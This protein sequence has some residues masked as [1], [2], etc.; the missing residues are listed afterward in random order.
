M[1]KIL[2]ICMMLLCL[3]API[4][5]Q[6][7]LAIVIGN[8]AYQDVPLS[9]PAGN[10]ITVSHSLLGLGFDVIRLEDANAQA[11]QFDNSKADTVIIYFSGKV[12]MVDKKTVLWSV[13]QNQKDDPSGWHL[14]DL[15]SGFMDAGSKRVLVF[16]DICHNELQP[17]KLEALSALEIDNVFQAQ[18]IKPGTTCSTVKETSPDFTQ[19][20]I[21]TLLTPN[22]PLSKA[23]QDTDA[24]W[25]TSSLSHP[26][27]LRHADE[28]IKGLTSAD[29]EMLDRLSDKD[30]KKMLSLWRQAGIIQDNSAGL[31]TP[32]ST[33]VIPKIRKTTI[34]FTA[35]VQ[36]INIASPLKPVANIVLAK[37]EPHA[38]GGVRI[39][40]AVASSTNP[41]RQFQPTKAGLPK[42]SI[43]VGDIKSANASFNATEIGGALSGT[44]IGG[45]GFK[46]RQKLRKEDPEM[47]EKLLIGGAF[48]P[49][50]EMLPAAIQT[51]LAR[52]GCYASRVDGIWGNGSRAA[53]DRYYKRLGTDAPTRKPEISLF[54]QIVRKDS[55]V[56]PVSRTQTR[57]TRVS[58]STRRS[59]RAG[60][61]R[62]RTQRT[63][64]RTAA[65]PA[66]STGPRTIKRTM[67]ASGVFR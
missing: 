61:N 18:A 37:H 9:K 57:S 59:T 6:E 22:V 34:L 36:P 20:L 44:E 52:M 51:E 63:K 46:A 4:A 39:F 50:P 5:A 67:N 16:L 7:R 43:I 45:T 10:A 40:T 56:C 23:F 19:Q 17:S 41:A 2:H 29:L 35:P 1:P 54:H 8:G 3:T 31:D 58:S 42:P 27:I 28:Q 30:R 49:L 15:V 60:S 33:V 66:A 64:P 12:S 13:G 14:N 62:T 24:I 65:K 48:D 47:F 53:V 38:V 32:L 26:Y 25:V 11:Y 55:V 21:K